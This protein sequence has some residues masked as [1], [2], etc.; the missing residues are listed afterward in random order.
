[1]LCFVLTWANGSI[2]T[3]DYIQLEYYKENIMSVNIFKIDFKTYFDIIHFF[4]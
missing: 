4:H 2:R 1:M 3:Y